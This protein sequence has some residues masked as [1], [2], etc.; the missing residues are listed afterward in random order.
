MSY[1]W[2]NVCVHPRAQT[3]EQLCGMQV[4]QL[5]GMDAALFMALGGAGRGADV[6]YCS[7]VY[8]LIYVKPEVIIR[9]AEYSRTVCDI[10]IAYRR[11]A[12]G[13]GTDTR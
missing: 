3:C 2:C 10:A 6:L 9:K 13:T 8:Y 1:V 5:C 12:T 7:R 11:W 4:W